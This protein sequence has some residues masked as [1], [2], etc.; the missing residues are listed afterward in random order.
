MKTML[1]ALLALTSVS[2]FANCLDVSGK[3]LCPAEAAQEYALGSRDL[4]IKKSPITDIYSVSTGSEAAIYEVNAWNPSISPSTG[5]IDYNVETMAQ[6][7]AKSVMFYSK[8]TT[9]DGD[10]SVTMTGGLD[11]RPTADGVVVRILVDEDEFFK[12]NCKKI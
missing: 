6:C 9:T 5:D 11:V 3:Y 7:R 10:I 2:S 8:V 4:I 1:L 12:F